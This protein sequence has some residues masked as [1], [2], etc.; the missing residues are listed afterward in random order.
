MLAIWVLLFR[1]DRYLE[2]HT[3]LTLT[4]IKQENLDVPIL[5]E[6]LYLYAPVSAPSVPL[7]L[8]S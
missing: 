3:H 4:L 7:R 5:N 6:K 2:E 1:A 8:K